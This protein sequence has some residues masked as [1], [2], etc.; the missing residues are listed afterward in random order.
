MIC[1]EMISEEREKARV[2]KNLS[3]LTEQLHRLNESISHKQASRNEYDKTIQETEAAYMKV[4]NTI[5]NTIYSL[6][7]PANTDIL[8][9]TCCYVPS[10]RYWNLRKPCCM[11]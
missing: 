8:Y 3:E 4:E 9:T 5:K 6:C 10:L 11:F 1:T 7:S 2:Q